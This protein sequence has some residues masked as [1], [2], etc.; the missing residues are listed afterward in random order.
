MES[1]TVPV[2]VFQEPATLVVAPDSVSLT[3]GDTATLRARVMDANGHDLPLAGGGQRGR[4]V[5][6]A[7]GHEEVATVAGVEVDRPGNRGATAT[8]A[9]A[10][11]GT[12]TITGT[13]MILDGT[14]LVYVIGEAT[15]TVTEPPTPDNG[16]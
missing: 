1:A 3:V 15:E 5:Y 9:A 14:G 8:V 6:W 11:A 10:A 13:T 12:A 7:T 4:V 16:T 2:T